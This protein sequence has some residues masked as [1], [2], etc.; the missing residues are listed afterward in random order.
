LTGV[1]I[2]VID[3]TGRVL[4][5]SHQDFRL[6]E[7]HKGR[8]DIDEALKGEEIT[9]ERYSKTLKN[10]MLY[11]SSPIYKDGNLIGVLRLSSFS[12]IYTNTS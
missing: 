1:R 8:K 5:D 6:M 4:A 10:K 3:T 7:N 9:I 2:T 11:F 12:K